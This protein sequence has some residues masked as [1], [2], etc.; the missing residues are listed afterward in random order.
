MSGKS[1]GKGVGFAFWGHC[2]SVLG[3]GMLD[4]GEDPYLCSWIDAHPLPVGT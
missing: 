2:R 1:Q 3:L 4:Y